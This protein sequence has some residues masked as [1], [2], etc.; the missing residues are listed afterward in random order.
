MPNIRLVCC[1]LLLPFFAASQSIFDSLRV[2]HRAEVFFAF[3]KHNIDTAALVVL[4]SFAASWVT[5]PNSSDVYITA[6]TDSVGNPGNNMALSQRRAEAVREALFKRGLP[7]AKMETR[8]FGEY[9]PLAEN[10]TEEG[11]QRNRRVVIEIGTILPMSPY[12][13]QVTDKKTGEGITATVHFSTRTLRDS[14]QTDSAGRFSVRLPT[15]SVVKTEV[16]AQGY[17]FDSYMQRMYGS[18]E[19][20]RRMQAEPV[21]I[22]LPAAK[23]GEKMAIKNL[24]F[25]GN[26]AILLK[27]SEPELPK[28]L[29]FLQANPDLRVEIAGH[30][31]NPIKKPSEL[32]KWEW[33]LSVNRAKT[34]YVYLRKNGIAPERMAFKGYGNT[35]MLFPNFGAT[36]AEQEQN[37]RVEI[38]IQ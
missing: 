1:L 8:A 20:I 33:N 38:R 23:S 15:D 26:E 16:Y 27:T 34:V 24:F 10:T 30:I 7:A 3:G 22:A 21:V 6:H 31:N 19:M 32:E 4:D 25:V 9:Q 35:E 17:F 5:Q 28:V 2:A 12:S 18:P 13:G 29:K 11:R 14:V 36:E 37:R